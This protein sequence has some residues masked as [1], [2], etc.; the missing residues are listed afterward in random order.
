MLEKY[1]QMFAKPRE[2]KGDV[3]DSLTFSGCPGRPSTKLD[4]RRM[5]DHPEIRA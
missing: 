4:E 3:L 5:P 1:L 2:G